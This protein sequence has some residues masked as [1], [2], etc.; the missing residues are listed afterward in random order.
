MI[1]DLE[2]DILEYEVKV[3]GCDPNGVEVRIAT[4]IVIKLTE[5][6]LCARPCYKH[7]LAHLRNS[8][9]P[10]TPLPQFYKNKKMSRKV[11]YR[12]T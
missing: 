10:T 8:L 12:W 6:I 11:K 4:T 3:E 7:K 1:T 2:P 9:E 5:H